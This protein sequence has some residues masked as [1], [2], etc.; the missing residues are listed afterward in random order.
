MKPLSIVLIFM[1]LSILA[2]GQNR[3]VVTARGFY[4]MAMAVDS[5]PGNQWVFVTIS[6]KAEGAIYEDTLTLWVC[7]SMG[8]I[9]NRITSL[10]PVQN[11][12]YLVDQLIGLPIAAFFCNMV[13]GTAM[14][15]VI[16]RSL[17]DGKKMEH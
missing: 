13:A 5:L 9:T 10:P 8:K 3:E 6:S 16:R 4:N 2:F 12:I 1:S 11:E 7:D 15:V 14:H 17:N